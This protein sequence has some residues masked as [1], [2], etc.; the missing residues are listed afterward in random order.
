MN[1]N[2]E[3]YLELLNKLQSMHEDD[4]EYDK[5]LDSM[6]GVW[7]SMNREEVDEIDCLI[8]IFLRDD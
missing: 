5:L 7:Y 3:K 2:Q 8:S 4:L 1:F 6:D